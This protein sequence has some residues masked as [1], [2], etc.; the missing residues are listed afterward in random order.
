M[1]KQ[2]KWF[3]SSDKSTLSELT[4]TPGPVQI[5]DVGIDGDEDDGTADME[6]NLAAALEDRDSGGQMLLVERKS[7]DISLKS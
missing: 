4:L 5:H 2:H 3:I 1:G 7:N 6:R